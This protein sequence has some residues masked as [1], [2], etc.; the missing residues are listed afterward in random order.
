MK[1]EPS[2]ITI[3]LSPSWDITCYGRNLEWGKHQVIEK[4]TIFP[5]GKAF[6]ISRALA[7]M[8]QL[9]IAA[10]F[11]GEGDFD[12]FKFFSDALW[13]LISINMTFVE[14]ETR[15]NVT[16]VDTATRREMHLRDKT[17]LYS[18]DSFARLESNLKKIVKMGDICVFSGA[19]PKGEYVDDV[20][21]IIKS[22]YN[23]GAKVVLDTSGP[24]LRRIIDS[25]L[26]W[27]IKP[28]ISELNELFNTEIEDKS[29]ILIQA[30]QKLLEQT[31]NVL[32]SR[33]ENGAIFINK[34]GVWQGKAV[35]NKEVLNTVGCGDY[36]LAG[37]IKNM[38]DSGKEE[39]VLAEAMKIATAKAW[40]LT[41]DK[42]CAEVM[43]ELQ[44]DVV[45]M[46]KI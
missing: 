16:L 3:G 26:V 42:L 33:G 22:C 7:W 32:I 1:N 43:V 38:M 27:F 35:N 11:W 18:K 14:G 41:Q 40:N 9:S 46:G 6:N 15:K 12:K 23:T 19:M 31:E 5:A 20:L 45:K 13:P 30:G 24:A 37:F 21:R 44:V 10:G 25:G 4:Q 34:K 2:I 8:G 29:A 28:N 36:L 17:N 39:V